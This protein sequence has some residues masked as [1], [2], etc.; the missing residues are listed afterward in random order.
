MWVKKKQYVI[1][2]YSSDCIAFYVVGKGSTSL[3]S[4]KPSLAGRLVG[5]VYRTRGKGL[6]LTISI[7]LV[8][9]HSAGNKCW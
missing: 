1:C 6:A 7:L 9:I 4:Y 8:L 3:A 5:V 2:S